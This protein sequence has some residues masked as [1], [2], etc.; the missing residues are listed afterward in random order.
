MAGWA[1]PKQFGYWMASSGLMLPMAKTCS[2]RSRAQQGER[3]GHSRVSWQLA[4][5]GRLLLRCASICSA[6]QRASWCVE[7]SR[8]L[9]DSIQ[10]NRGAATLPAN[11]SP[12]HPPTT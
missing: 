10:A 2:A 5:A 4:A 1:W 11:I 12:T 8:L 3:I 9:Q 6:R 7:V